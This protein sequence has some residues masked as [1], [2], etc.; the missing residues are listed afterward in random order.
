V[1]QQIAS[2]NAGFPSTVLELVKSGRFQKGKW[3]KRLDQTDKEQVRNALEMVGMWG[4]RHHKIGSLSGGQKQKI[5]IA[6]VLA[7]E[8]DV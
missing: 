3:F 7:S 8:P 4:Y 2:F 1:P 6:R 5:C